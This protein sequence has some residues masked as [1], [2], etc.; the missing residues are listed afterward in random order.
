[1]RGAMLSRKALSTKRCIET[2]V[3]WFGAAGAAVGKH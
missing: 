3:R 1:M 2:H